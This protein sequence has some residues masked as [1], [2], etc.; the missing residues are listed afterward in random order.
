MEQTLVRW[1]LL[2]LT[3]PFR[4]IIRLKLPSKIAVLSLEDA[5]NA[6][7]LLDALG[8]EDVAPKQQVFNLLVM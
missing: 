2:R 8:L 7:E 5:E 4:R 6:E 1:R 3:C